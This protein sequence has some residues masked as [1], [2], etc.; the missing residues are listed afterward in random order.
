MISFHTINKYPY[1]YLIWISNC[2]FF[3]KRASKSHTIF[4][5]H[6]NLDL[7]LEIKGPI[8]SFAKVTR[9]PAK[10]DIQ[11]TTAECS[12]A[13][14]LVLQFFSSFKRRVKASTTLDVHSRKHTFTLMLQNIETLKDVTL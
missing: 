8:N 1:S 11:H 2:V 3:L 9:Q 6:K 14:C 5:F 10:Q 7:I 13:I 12:S 4:R